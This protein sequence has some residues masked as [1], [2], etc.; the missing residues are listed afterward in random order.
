MMYARFA[1]AVMASSAS[2][3]LLPVA[4]S[5]FP[6]GLTT[7]EGGSFS[8]FRP[9]VPMAPPKDP[10][11]S[12][13]SLSE[14]LGPRSKMRRRLNAAVQSARR[15]ETS[16]HAASPALASF[17]ADSAAAPVSSPSPVIPEGNV[18]RI[19][20]AHPSARNELRSVATDPA[21]RSVPGSNPVWD[22]SSPSST[23]SAYTN[24]AGPFPSKSRSL[25]LCTAGSAVEAS[26]KPT[27]SRRMLSRVGNSWRISCA[28]SRTRALLDRSTSSNKTS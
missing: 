11:D 5:S 14:A 9:I 19:S 7:K 6:C 24:S 12:D 8:S 17:A 28:F 18:V 23:C 13:G 4:S 3:F 20:L 15:S 16:R 1:S 27:S 22:E 10:R 25:P 2:F 26:N 21:V